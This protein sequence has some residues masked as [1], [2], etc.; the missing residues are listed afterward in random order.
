VRTDTGGRHFNHM[1]ALLCFDSERRA[2]N[3]TGRTRRGLGVCCAKTAE[4]I[5]IPSGM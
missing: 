3:K 5:A 1:S 4:P 2:N